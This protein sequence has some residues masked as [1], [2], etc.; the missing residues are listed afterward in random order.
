MN[1]ATSQFLKFI[2]LILKEELRDRSKKCNSNNLTSPPPLLNVY[3][4]YERSLKGEFQVIITRRPG[5]VVLP[6]ILRDLGQG[7]S[8]L[9]WWIGGNRGPGYFTRKK[10]TFTAEPWNSYFFQPKQCFFFWH[11]RALWTKMRTAVLELS[12]FNLFFSRVELCTKNCF[13]KNHFL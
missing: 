8:K 13:C 12:N 3:L 6:I 5:R 11:P 10:E 1:S 9:R 4:F 2:N 7:N